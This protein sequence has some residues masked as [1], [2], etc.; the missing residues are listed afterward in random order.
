LHLQSSTNQH[1]VR[2]VGYGPFSLYVIHNEGLMMIKSRDII[3]IEV[4]GPEVKAKSV[5]ELAAN[6]IKNKTDQ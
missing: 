3:I 2:V 5:M 6:L 4:K 1:W